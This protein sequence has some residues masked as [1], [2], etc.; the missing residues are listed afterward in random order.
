MYIY[1]YTHVYID[2]Y[3]YV[4]ISPKCPCHLPLYDP[5]DCSSWP[6][7]LGMTCFLESGTAIG[8]QVRVVKFLQSNP[9]GPST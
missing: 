3:I 2:I 6:R 9:A 8:P 7:G 4:C 1:V 5:S